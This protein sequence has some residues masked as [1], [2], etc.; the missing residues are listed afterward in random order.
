VARRRPI[1]SA[2]EVSHVASGVALRNRASGH[3]Q[4]RGVPAGSTVVQS[5]VFWNL[6]DDQIVGAPTMPLLFN[7]NLVRGRKTADNTEPCWGNIGNHS[8]VATVTPFTNQTGGPN[9]DYEV[10]LP[11]SLNTS[12]SGQNPWSPVEAA[13][14]RLEGATLVV[15]FRNGQTRGPLSVFAPAGD[16]MFFF[17]ASY[18]FPTPGT[19]AG[20]FTAFGAD[21]QR[22]AGHSDFLSGEV[23]SFVSGGPLVDLAGGASPTGSDWDGDDG[24]TLPQLW[25]THT[26]VVTFGGPQATVRYSSPGDC[27]VPVG[28]VLDQ[29]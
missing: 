7:G 4:T 15:I 23:T 5:F 27:I 14:V 21:G 22:G 10:V 24:L 16:N 17:N 19:G 9:Q 26:H 8:Y 12:T 13:D 28:F 29:E 11:F 1:F 18:T 20:L 3:I 6:S 2:K 25:D